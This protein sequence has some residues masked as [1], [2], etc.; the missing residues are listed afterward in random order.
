LGNIAKYCDRAVYL[1]KGKMVFL[2]DAREAVELYQ[3]DNRE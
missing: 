3:K 2:G 1:K